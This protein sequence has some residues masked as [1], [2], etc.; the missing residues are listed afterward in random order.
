M[1]KNGKTGG[2]ATDTATTLQ[3]R[4]AL[5]GPI[6]DAFLDSFVM[7]RP[8]GKAAIESIGVWV[9]NEMDYAIKIWRS[10]FRGEA[11]VK[12]DSAITQADIANSNLILWGDPSSNKILAQIADKLPIKWNAD[13]I[14]AG[15]QTYSSS[16]H[17]PILIFP[18]PLN[19][20]RY[21]VL[22]SG[23]TFREDNASNARQTPKL[24][25]WAL[26]DITVPPSPLRVGRVVN[27]GFFGER[28]E[29]K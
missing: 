14:Q 18:N 5:Q 23:F 1:Q 4:H 3:K 29:L 9:K 15:N 8:T 19:P 12:N 25:D 6:D 21:V 13:H 10:Q 11:H 16:Q 26:V 24:P 7:V 20:K 22:N 2:I 27:A 17:I 28:W